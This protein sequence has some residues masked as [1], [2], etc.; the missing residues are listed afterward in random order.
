ME[1]VLEIIERLK[2]RR[3]Y[4][5]AKKTGLSYQGLL[6]IVNGVTKNPSTKTID[7]LR[8]YLDDNK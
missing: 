7:K 2:D 8:K 1:E 4:R 5:V 6:N 3:L